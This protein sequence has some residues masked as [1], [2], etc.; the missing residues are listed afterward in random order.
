MPTCRM[1]V[2]HVKTTLASGNYDNNHAITALLAKH[3]ANRQWHRERCRAANPP[4][5]HPTKIAAIHRHA[6]ATPTC[7]PHHH[8]PHDHCQKRAC[9]LTNTA[10][11]AHAQTA[12]TKQGALPHC[13]HIHTTHWC[14]N[15]H[16]GRQTSRC[17]GNGIECARQRSFSSL[18][19][20]PRSARSS[21]RATNQNQPCTSNAGISVNSCMSTPICASGTLTA[22]YLSRASVLLATS[23]QSFTT[24]IVRGPR[25]R[26]AEMPYNWCQS[27]TM[28]R[29]KRITHTSHL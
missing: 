16:A 14:R 4:K 27:K 9:V 25:T 24:V 22:K 26:N 28:G 19:Q 20:H 13:G 1:P 11:R 3:G 2:C 15:R 29:M 23:S 12:H 10:Q 6:P 17:H 8:A 21:V 5:P 18:Q 7:R